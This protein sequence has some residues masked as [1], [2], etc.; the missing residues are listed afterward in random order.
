MMK[1][2]KKTFDCI[3]M[4]DE[5]QKKRASELAGMSDAEKLEYY[6]KAH[7]ALVKQQESLRK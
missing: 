4:K 7:A 2:K 3:Q 6:R 5:A 1:T